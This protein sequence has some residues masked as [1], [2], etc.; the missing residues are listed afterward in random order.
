MVFT[1]VSLY[2]WSFSFGWVLLP[3]PLLIA[4][5]LW[6]R[7]ALLTPHL[8][9][10][11]ERR[12]GL[13]FIVAGLLTLPVTAGWLN[14][15]ACLAC[16]WQRFDAGQ[17]GRAPVD[18]AS[19]WPAILLYVVSSALA[20]YGFW[21]Y[22]RLF[23]RSTPAVVAFSLALISVGVAAWVLAFSLPSRG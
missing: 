4:L 2:V 15:Q 8:E 3:L 16:E 12:E 17:L 5:A 21:R 14:W 19:P 11:P 10:A 7:S 1:I 9:R 13:P 23:S 18:I 22:R 6:F 20:A